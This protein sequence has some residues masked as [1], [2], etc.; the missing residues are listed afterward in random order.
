MNVL[1]RNKN[2]IVGTHN[3]K[4]TITNNNVFIS[5]FTHLCVTQ[6]GAI[7]IKQTQCDGRY[8]QW[9]DTG[10]GSSSGIC[11]GKCSGGGGDGGVGSS[12][13]GNG[14]EATNA[15][16]CG[17]AASTADSGVDASRVQRGETAA[18]ARDSVG[19]DAA[20]IDAE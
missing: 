10:S 16:E 15:R 8:E 1:E 12:D 18:A 6:C 3:S 4:S 19:Y 7:L 13:G 5:L 20:W 14:D 11:G 2:E 17:S 9:I